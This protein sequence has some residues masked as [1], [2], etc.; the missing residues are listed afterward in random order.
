M[1]LYVINVIWIHHQIPFLSTI[2]ELLLL[3]NIINN[4]S[5]ILFTRCAKKGGGLQNKNLKSIT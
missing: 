1:L 2:T 3:T 5:D 4:G